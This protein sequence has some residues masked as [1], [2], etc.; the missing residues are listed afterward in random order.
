[1][2]ISCYGYV[3]SGLKSDYNIDSNQGF[4]YDIILYFNNCLEW[5]GNIPP[6]QIY[7]V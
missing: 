7:T 2:I 5:P 3:S 4:V 1:M 6:L